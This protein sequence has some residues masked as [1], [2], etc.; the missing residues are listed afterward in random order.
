MRVSPFLPIPV[1]LVIVVLLLLMKRKGWWNY[2]RQIIVAVLIFLVNLRILIPTGEMIEV[3][4]N[5]DILFVIDNTISML[6]ED[7]DG[8]ERRIDAVKKDVE[9]IVDEFVGSRFAVISFNDQAS[10]MVPYTTEK[11]NVMLAVSSLEG[12]SRTYAGGSSINVVYNKMKDYLEGSYIADKDKEEDEDKEER[13]QIVFFISDGEMNTGDRL[14]SFDKMAEFING[15][16]VLGYGTEE[17][18][19]MRVRNYTSSQETTILEYFDREKV[20]YVEAVSKIDE[21]TLKNLADE[22]NLDYYHMEDKKDAF[23]VADDIHDKIDS[24]EMTPGSTP[25][26]GYG[27]TYHIF[28]IILFVFLMYDLIYYGMK[29]GRG[30]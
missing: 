19:K 3:T 15:G 14:K 6:A 12:R 1:I 11:E 25:Q 10:V 21:K 16:A 13:V 26:M 24:G 17:G 4:N 30:Q 27:E 7:Y 23:D 5:V 29:M 22:M 20:R 8:E 28:A 9:T 2:T 18:G